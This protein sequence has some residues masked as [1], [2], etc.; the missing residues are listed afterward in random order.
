MRVAIISDRAYPFQKGGAEKRYHSLAQH[1]VRHGHHVDWYTMNLWDGDRVLVADGIRYIAV[2]DKLPEYSSG[3]RRSIRQAV[4]FA[5]ACLRLLFTKERY[6]V[7]DC[8]QYPFFTIP[9]MW[10]VAMRWRSAF[11]VTWYETCGDHW[12]EYLGRWGGIGQWVERLCARIPP[13]L[14][15]ISEQSLR[16][17]ETQGLT[18]RAAVHIPLGIDYELIQQAPKAPEQV[19]VIYFGRLK[20]HKNVDLLL[21]AIALARKRRPSLSAIIAGEGPEAD[22]LR[23]LAA[24]LNL[25]GSVTFAGRVESEAELFGLVKSA[26]VFVHPSTKEGGGSLVTMEANAC[27]TPVI[28]IAHPLGVDRS[29]IEEGVNGFWVS[30]ASPELLAE[31]ILSVLADARIDNEWRNDARRLSRAYDLTP[32]SARIEKLYERLA[33]LERTST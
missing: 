6:D 7:V 11:V 30:R 27:G 14:I 2:C 5:M 29:L 33:T 17:F 22:T 26:R 31:R 9:V 15:V 24:N 19:D 23:R 13:T 18:P 1:L 20:N 28:A 25:N 16:R 32:I 12:L 8:S 3:G 10:L 4:G 21:R